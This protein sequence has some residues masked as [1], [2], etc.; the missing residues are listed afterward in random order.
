M[1]TVDSSFG[2]RVIRD[3]PACVSAQCGEAL[4]GEDVAAQLE[5]VVVAR[6]RRSV[7]KV[8]RCSQT[9]P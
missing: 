4:S 3:G 8:T 9:A 2:V 1:S 5:V 6:P 7:I